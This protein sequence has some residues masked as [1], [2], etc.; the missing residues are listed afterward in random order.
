[1]I[2]IWDRIARRMLGEHHS[3][4]QSCKFQRRKILQETRDKRKAVLRVSVLGSKVAEELIYDE[5][6]KFYNDHKVSTDMLFR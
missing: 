2:N 1:M 5:K 4:W 3:S 6:L